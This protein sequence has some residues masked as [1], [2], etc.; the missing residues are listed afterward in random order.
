MNT[1]EIN[2]KYE[3][4]GQA[5]RKSWIAGLIQGIFIGISAE[6]VILIILRA[7]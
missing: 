6:G 1:D 7:I 2:Q 4:I 3:E 5:E